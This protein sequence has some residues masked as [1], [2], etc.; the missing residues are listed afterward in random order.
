MCEF[1]SSAD[2]WA[3]IVGGIVAGFTVAGAFRLRD[4]RDL[5]ILNDLT[6][7]MGRAI[8]HRIIGENRSFTNEKEWIRQADNIE[9][10][11]IAK[12]KKL[13]PLAGAL[14]EWLDRLVKPWDVT[15]EVDRSVAILATVSTR[16]RELLERHS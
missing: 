7:I 1:L 14:I 3:N 10:E 12:A 6:E 5:K 2:L 16:I 15:N 8:N 4:R 9:I 13:S 11:A